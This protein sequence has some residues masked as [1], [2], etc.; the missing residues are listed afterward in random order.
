MTALALDLHQHQ[1]QHQTLSPRLQRAVKLLQL[2]TAEFSQTIGSLL[3]ENPFLEA[4]EP[5]AAPEP[6]ALAHEAHDARAQDALAGAEA[7]ISI[8]Q[9]PEAADLQGWGSADWRASARGAETDLGPL[10]FAAAATT[11]QDHLHSQ[12]RLLRLQDREFLLASVLVES[13]EEDGY[14]RQELEEIAALA[15]LDPPAEPCELK[16]ALCRVQSLEPAGIGARD[17]AE[18]LRLQLA[19]IEPEQDR[20]LCAAVL[21]HDAQWLAKLDLERLARDLACPVEQIRHALTLLRRLD[22]HP[23]WRYG[24]QPTRYVMPDVLVRKVRGG[25]AAMLNDAVVP[26]IRVNRPY[27]ELLR[28]NRKQ[29]NAALTAQ[30]NE[31]RWTVRNVEQR[32][33]TILSVAQSILKRQHRFLEYGPMAMRPLGL[34]EI[35]EEVGVHES[36]VSR[37]TN[38]KY[39]ATPCGTYELKYFFSRAMNAEGNR[40]CSPIAVRGLVGAIIESEVPSRPLSDVAIAE[41]LHRQGI[42]VARRT[43]TKYRQLLGFKPAEQRGVMPAR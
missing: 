2:S 3:D 22:P 34:K 17:L 12:L 4:E 40:P 6:A 15:Q 36:T 35:A 16:T 25:W 23:G 1:G 37:V 33:S 5:L 26:R 32:F 7:S 19:T 24:S 42:R 29:E 41:Q 13:L 43:V 14:L 9:S 38:N 28:R 18:C 8:L 27:A 10:E 20:A 39:M 30:L 11:L 31:A 21:Q